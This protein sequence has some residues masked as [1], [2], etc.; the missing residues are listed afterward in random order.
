[1][2]IQIEE[3]VSNCRE[4]IESKSVVATGALTIRVPERP[5]VITFLGNHP[6]EGKRKF[7][8]AM[9]ICWPTAA[10]RL[11]QREKHYVTPEEFRI[12]IEEEA[13]DGSTEIDRTILESTND[14]GL[15]SPNLLMVYFIC[16]DDE[17]AEKFITLLDR[18]YTTPMGG[19]KER[20]IFAVGKLTSNHALR[21]CDKFV[22][23]LRSAAGPGSLA[24]TLWDHTSCMMLSNYMY[25]GTTL[26]AEEYLDNYSLAMDILLMQ[27]SI[28]CE[29]D[30]Y[31]SRMLPRVTDP[32]TPF[33]TATLHR[34]A[35]PFD[36]IA[37]TLLYRFL[38]HGV[39]MANA[40]GSGEMS[41]L[42]LSQDA[43]KA[44]IERFKAIGGE[45]V[46]P[47]ES[48]MRHFPDGAA[49]GSDVGEDGGTDKTMG[50]WALF[51]KK[52]FESKALETITDKTELKDYF[53]RYFSSECGCSCGIIQKIFPSFRAHLDQIGEEAFMGITRPMASATIRDWGLYYAKKAFGGVC[54]AALKEAVSELSRSAGQYVSMLVNLSGQVTPSNSTVNM[55]YSNIADGHMGVRSG[56]DS[57]EDMLKIPCGE[58]EMLERMKS[59]VESITSLPQLRMNFFEELKARL[60]DDGANNTVKSFLQLPLH[61]L[62]N[63]ARM[64]VG[65]LEDICEATLFDS[66][67]LGVVS[68][69]H[70]ELCNTNSM[71]RV[72]LYKFDGKVMLEE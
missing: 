59:F 36:Q 53:C 9:Q 41:D 21:Q 32:A 70:F 26:S 10:Y 64:H 61:T 72:V 54:F 11:S 49:R 18:P 69:N 35:K 60:A 4:K 48:A 43:Q 5:V 42:S 58:D 66:N 62:R 55:Y 30:R 57:F 31:S 50:T 15:R 39:D 23:D 65:V 3:F 8:S 28:R 38:R 37:R 46:F 16:F 29:Q 40:L 7:D 14:T 52:Y 63:D 33:M 25:G 24:A 2:P 13:A 51:R 22:S 45:N 6:V 67:M 34:E 27:Y 71:D 20:F 12:A 17:N 47:T 1:M 44:V 68:G 56:S 19:E